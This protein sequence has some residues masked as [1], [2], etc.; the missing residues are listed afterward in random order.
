MLVFWGY[1]SY[2]IKLVFL[3]IDNIFRYTHGVIFLFEYY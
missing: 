1:K 2:T 3:R